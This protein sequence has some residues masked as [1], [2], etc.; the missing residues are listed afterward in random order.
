[1]EQPVSMYRFSV[2]CTTFGCDARQRLAVECVEDEPFEECKARANS[3]IEAN[4]WRCDR[5]GFLC[6]THAAQA[7]GVWL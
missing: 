2:M 3:L 1:V 6:P 4:G 5:L 7:V